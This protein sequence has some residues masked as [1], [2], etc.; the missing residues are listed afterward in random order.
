MNSEITENRRFF[1]A[2]NSLNTV[3]RMLTDDDDPVHPIE[4]INFAVFL[5]AYL[6]E[7][8]VAYVTGFDE[9]EAP[10]RVSQLLKEAHSQVLRVDEFSTADTSRFAEGHSDEETADRFGMP[11]DEWKDTWEQWHNDHDGPHDEEVLALYEPGAEPLLHF[12]SRFY[13]QIFH[14]SVVKRAGIITVPEFYAAYTYSL[15]EHSLSQRLYEE[16]ESIY[17]SQIQQIMAVSRPDRIYIPPLVAVLLGRCKGNPRALDMEIFSMYEELRP[18]RARMYEAEL[19]MAATT[20]LREQIRRV[21]EFEAA[22]ETMRRSLQLGGTQ[23]SIIKKTWQYVSAGAALPKKVIDKLI[24]WDD[25]QLRISPVSEFISMYAQ[26][27]SFAENQYWSL[28][29]STYRNID[30]RAFRRFERVARRV[31]AVHTGIAWVS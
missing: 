27:T 26:A 18:F 3:E 10:C 30:R 28:L 8:A 6:L 22:I 11:L 24:E 4:L 17:R 16:M 25:H 31:D 20:D 1:F 2:G 5:Q 19:A 7:Y 14:K 21:Q 15:E 9:A 23:Q 13:G 12:T 29:A